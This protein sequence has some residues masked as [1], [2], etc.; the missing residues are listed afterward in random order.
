MHRSQH[1]QLRG[2]ADDEGF[3]SPQSSLWDLNSS[4]PSSDSDGG[5]P[6]LPQADLIIH[7][8]IITFLDAGFSMERFVA[9]MISHVAMAEHREAMRRLRIDLLAHSLVMEDI[10][11]AVTVESVTLVVADVVADVIE[12]LDNRQVM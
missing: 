8:D 4:N 1:L 7:P 10:V 3:N 6:P 11:S 12:E 5:T 9:E 2:G